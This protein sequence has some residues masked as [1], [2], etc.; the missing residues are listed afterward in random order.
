VSS[1]P[2]GD[3]EV[4]AQA[5]AHP[6]R[7]AW[8]GCLTEEAPISAS[9]FR[10][11]EKL[12]VGEQRTELSEAAYHARALLKTGVVRRVAKRGHERFYALSF[13]T[14]EPVV[15]MVEALKGRRRL[16]DGHDAETLRC[17]TNA[18]LAG[19]G[20]VIGHPIRLAIAR[21]MYL[22]EGTRS[23]AIWARETGVEL[24]TSHITSG[25]SNRLGLPR[26][27]RV[28][29]RPGSFQHFYVLRSPLGQP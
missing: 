11:R 16:L 15:A 28:E 9:G 27:S 22:A 20:R 3:R 10:I 18:Q 13:P 6:V 2:L 23:P 8:I 26:L 21:E 17:L 19:V 4:V 5:L 1:S 14:A 29:G 25:C 7:A 12:R 24:R